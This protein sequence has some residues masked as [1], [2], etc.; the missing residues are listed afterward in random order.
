MAWSRALPAPERLPPLVPDDFDFVV[1][2]GIGGGTPAAAAH[3][4]LR[5][6]MVAVLEDAIRCLLGPVPHHRAQAEVW[7]F[8]RRTQSPFAFDTVCEVLGLDAGAVRRSLRAMARER[9]PGGPVRGRS[10]PN[11]RRTTELGSPVR[12]RSRR[13]GR[14]SLAGT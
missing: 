1:R 12:R 9:A 6:L 11:V 5:A 7:M 14:A 4:G 8:S 3:S 2:Q 13:H 10:R